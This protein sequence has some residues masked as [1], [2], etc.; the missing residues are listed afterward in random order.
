[1][2][3]Q[4]EIAGG[5]RTA[6]HRDGTS[7]G[8]TRPR[9]LIASSDLRTRKYLARLL[10]GRWSIATAGN[11]SGALK[12]A[13]ACP[14][15]LVLCAVK[16]GNEGI[17]LLRELRA[18]PDTRNVPVIFLS[19]AHPKLLSA[20]ALEE[21]AADYVR[22]PVP[23]RELEARINRHLTQARTVSS[24]HQALAQAERSLRARDEFIL[25]LSHEIRNPLNAVMEWVALLQSGR[26]KAPARSHAYELLASSARLQQRLMDDLRDAREIDH[27]ALSLNCELLTGLGSVV[28]A[29]ADACRPGATLKGIRLHTFVAARTGPVK[30][31]IQRL[32]QALWNLLSNAIK[33]TP[34]GGSVTVRC[35]TAQNAV[36]IRVTDTGAG[37]TPQA[38]PHIFDRFRRGTDLVDG[39]GLGLAIVK[40]IVQLHGGSIRAVSEGAGRGASFIVRLPLVSVS[41]RPDTTAPRRS[42]PGSHDTPSLQILLAEDHI[43]SAKAIQRLLAGHGH[44]VRHA[45]A[46]TEAVELARES[47][48]DV[49]ICDLNLKD[50]SGV[51]LLTQVRRTCSNTDHRGLAAIA[52][53]GY[54][55]E[56]SKARTRAAGFSRHLEKPVDSQTLLEAVQQVFAEARQPAPSY[57]SR[58][59]LP[60]AGGATLTPL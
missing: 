48:P 44:R 1:M 27:G 21:G 12:W 49:L 42:T 17:Q 32:Q 52:M 34:A 36:E 50:G 54:L 37:I 33:F 60:D 11:S 47:P 55:D 39:L 38:M 6:R 20:Q 16:T 43:E 23:R 22:R 14:P 3:N 51:E 5:K 40:G 31:D 18:R 25:Q 58:T 53:S 41:S 57:R 19:H 59:R 29:V 24:A 45:S 56:A 8:T 4:P 13:D 9:I 7:R 10:S 26:L 2:R 35:L 30:V 28:K 15:D 46:V